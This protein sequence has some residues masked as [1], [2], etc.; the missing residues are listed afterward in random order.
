MIETIELAAGVTLLAVQTEKF[1]SGCFSFNLMRPHTRAAAPLDAL[2]PSVLLRGSERWP[3]MRAI[4]MRL[5]ELYGA[6]LGTLVRL[7]GETKLTGFY[8]DFIEEDFLPAG[9]AVFAPMVEFFRDI[10]FHPALENG[11][12]NARYVESEKQNLIHAIESAQNDKRVYA[13]MR[14]R[15]IMCE[16]EAASIPRLG[17]AEDVA[18]ITPEALTAHWRTVLRTAPIMLFY[19]GRRT[20]QEA[21]ALFRPLF[22]GLERD[23]VSPPPTVVR[24]SAE[25]VREITESMDVTQGKLVIGMRTGI[26]ASDPDY[27]ALVLLNSVYGSGV[28]SKLFV[29]VR[30][31]RSLC[32]YASSAVEKFKGLMIVS[33]GISFDQY[34]TAR[35]AILAELDACRRGEITPEEANRI[36]YETAMRW[37]K[38][39][40]AFFVATHTDKAHIHNHI[41]YNSTSL[42]CT[43]KFRDFIGSGRAVR[44]LSDRICL[45]ND[46]FVITN[47]K[48]HSKGRFLH[49][50]AWLGTERQPSHKEQLRLAI[51]EALAK[52]PADFDAFLRLMEASGFTVKHGRGGTI[53]FLVPGQERATRLRASTLGD[54]YDP[55]DIKAVIAGERP[56]PEQPVPAPAAPR[57]VNLIVDIQERLRSG[58]G[59]A[60]ARWAKVYNL[61]QMAAALQFMQEQNITEYDQLSAK[62]EDAV[63][64]FHAL[65]EQLRRTEADLSVTSELMGAVVRYAK[66]RP[67]FDGYKAAKY[68]RKYLAEHEAELADYRAAKATMGELLGGEKLPKMAELKEKRRQLAARKKALYAE[69]RSAQE[70]MR[71]SVAVKSN[72][73]HLLGVTDGQRKKEQER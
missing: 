57:R 14:M 17:Y 5:D 12:L 15:R 66:T 65:T 64:R 1:K 37:T 55:E 73:D 45:E 21:A 53:S 31:K 26:T 72:I 35:D 18:A 24:R 46:L 29:N 52:R 67:V 23:P 49:Y 60:Y 43:R 36:G 34:E 25:T 4:S 22:D 40:Y 71:Q 27:P 30:E 2:L 69:Y 51:N 70:E 16:G 56:L 33:S 38:G 58:K 8:A 42:D 28:T 68:S 32:Y 47:P 63:S 10:L 54:G 59:A 61:K 20:P 11:L 39:K 48:L 50:G 41:Y 3:D 19:A 7:R 6:T 44:R 13:A 62:A 9:E